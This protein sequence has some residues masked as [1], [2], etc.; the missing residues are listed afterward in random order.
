MS[1]NRLDQYLR[2]RI[3]RGPELFDHLYVLPCCAGRGPE[4]SPKVA[5]MVP[6]VFYESRA[7]CS[8]SQI[9][10]RLKIRRL[11]P[12]LLIDGPSGVHFKISNQV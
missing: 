10:N 9:Q 4:N 12:N 7:T 8:R 5:Y 2:D 6:I 11:L 3:Y 1:E